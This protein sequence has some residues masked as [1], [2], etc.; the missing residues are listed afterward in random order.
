M[1]PEQLARRN[2]AI[3][4]AWDDPLRLA[5]A[6]TEFEAARR[7]TH[8]IANIENAENRLTQMRDSYIF[9]IDDFASR[10]FSPGLY[11]ERRRVP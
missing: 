9:D 4:R 2:A 7:T 8:I 11:N 1:T 3:R 6:E 5:R 10:R